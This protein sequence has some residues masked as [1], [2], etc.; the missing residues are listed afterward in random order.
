MCPKLT[1]WALHSRFQTPMKLLAPLYP[2]T[3]IPSDMA[4][5]FFITTLSMPINLYTDIR[6]VWSP[7]P[8]QKPLLARPENK[9]KHFP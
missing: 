2:L 8:G 1:F 6:N 7:T 9:F 3:S 4:K 5:S